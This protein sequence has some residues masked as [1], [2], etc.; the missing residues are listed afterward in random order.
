MKILGIS[1]G[2]TG[3]VALLEDGRIVYAIHEE[4]LTREKMATGFPRQSIDRVL[5]D[6]HTAASEIDAIAIA[7]LNEF[8]RET[9]VGY[10]GWLR[11][12]QAPLKEV[13][14]NAA[15][16]ASGVTGGSS[17]LRESYYGVKSYLGKTRRKVFE[18]LLRSE[19]GFTCPVQ[20]INHHYAHAC[21]AYYTSG[22]SEAAVITMDG[23]GDN[24]SSHVYHV[25]NGRF[26]RLCTVSSFDS[27]GNYYAYVTHLCGFKAQKHEG[28]ITGL[29]AYGQ[30]VYTDL[31]KQFIG[32]EN[33]KTKN[34][35][36]VFYWAAVKALEKVLPKP[37]NR[38]DL[39]CSMQQVLEEISGTYIDHWVQKIGCGDLAVAGGVFANVKLNQR[40]HELKSVETVFIHPGMGDEGLALGAAFALADSMRSESDPLIPSQKLRDVYFGPDYDKN[41]IEKAIAQDGLRAEYVPDIERR[42]AELLADGLVVARFAGRMEYGPRAL[43]NRSVLYQTTDP[44]VNDWLNKQLKRTEF[45]PFAPVTLEEYAEHCY[46]GLAGATYPAQ[47]MTL[48]FNCT[49]WMKEHCPAVVHVDGTARPQLINAEAN[50]SYYKIVDEYRKITGLPSLINTSFN[51]HEEPIVCSPG[52][53]IRGFIDG[54]LDSLALGNFLLLNPKAAARRQGPA[55]ASSSLVG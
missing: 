33:G 55:G 25:Q 51:M 35:G 22:L 20:F 14:L 34:K 29:A 18:R 43:G 6:T 12:E 17:I 37:F 38:E 19:W 50:P 5:R 8:F 40:I 45:M 13:L 26:S 31:L 39:A 24:S 36:K 15:S 2:M 48:T 28:K 41:E 44:T 46:E 42:I 7:T 32:F 21:S 16:V 49:S 3:G 52:D 9:A 30:P 10:D 27:I 47:F 23:A 1:D 53:A 54:G 11:R 4:R